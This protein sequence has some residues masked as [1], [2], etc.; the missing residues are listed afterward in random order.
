[1]NLF[2]RQ[3]S[4]IARK[5]SQLQY[6]RKKTILKIYFALIL[7]ILLLSIGF[8]EPK[9]YL[10]INPLMKHEK[11]SL[12]YWFGTDWL[13]RDMFMRTLQG[14]QLSFFI[15]LVSSTL[16]AFIALIISFISTLHQKL[17]DIVTGIIDFFL[18]IPHL[19]TLILIAFVLG[20]G[21]KGIMF[22]IALTH[23][24]TL[25]RVLRAEILQVS[26]SE[27]VK[28]S[29]MLGKSRGWIFFQHYIPYIAPQLFVG[30]IMLFPHAI[31]HEAAVTFLGFGLSPEQPAIGIILAESMKYLT[32]GMW[33]LAL[34]PGL[35]LVILINLFD[36]LGRN[37]KL[38]YFP[39]ES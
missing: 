36:M 6:L 18:S 7:L 17:D 16:S 13:G 4:L 5:S 27:Y 34:F 3:K 15:G 11:P 25:G 35:L 20:G 38:L 32:M 2:Q 1:M 33:W 19:V 10:D 22:A 29:K 14:L 23:W 24:P 12:T 9:D 21:A 37:I 8:L 39:N 30:F 31:L 28:I 26:Q